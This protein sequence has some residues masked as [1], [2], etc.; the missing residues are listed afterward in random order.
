M[1]ANGES[2]MWV[3]QMLGHKMANITF[4]KYAKYIKE[5]KINR[6]KFINKWHIFGTN[7]NPTRLKALKQEDKQCL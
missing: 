3:S 7:D 1:L 2:I 4:E 5:D 6:A